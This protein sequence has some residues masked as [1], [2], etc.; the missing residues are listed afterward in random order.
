MHE[1]EHETSDSLPVS[2]DGRRPTNGAGDGWLTQRRLLRAYR[3]R[4]GELV[5]PI[6]PGLHTPHVDPDSLS[7]VRADLPGAGDRGRTDRELGA[8]AILVIL[9]ALFVGIRS[10]FLAMLPKSA[11][12]KQ[13][14]L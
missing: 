6:A 5:D 9:G 8:L 12:I 3:E 13:L 1:R 4:L 7:R 11:R 14:P 2:R 10:S